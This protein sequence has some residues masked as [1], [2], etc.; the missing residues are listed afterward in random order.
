M[1]SLE[2]NASKVAFSHLVQTCRTLGIDL[3]DCQMPNPHLLSLGAEVLSRAR[4]LRLLADRVDDTVNWSQMA[5]PLPA[6]SKDARSSSWQNLKRWSFSKHRVIP[7]VIYQNS[8][9]PRYLQTRT[10]WSA[11]ACTLNYH[12]SVFVGVAFTF[13]DR[14]A[15]LAELVSRF[16]YPYPPSNQNVVIR[17]SWRVTESWPSSNS[18]LTTAMRSGGCMSAISTIDILMATCSPQTANNSS[19]F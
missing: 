1:F 7:V 10:R 8:R 2:S 3:I 18:P 9:R 11:P 19:V 13:I 4:F 17:G 16:G 15:M 12:K 5:G 6:W 14:I